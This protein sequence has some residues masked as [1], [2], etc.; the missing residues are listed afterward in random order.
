M[1]LLM[2]MMMMRGDDDVLLLLMM[3]MMMMMMMMTA[4]MMLL[5]MMMVVVVVAMVMMVITRRYLAALREKVSTGVVG[6]SDLVK[7][8][9]QLGDSPN[10]FDYCFPENGLLAFKDGQQIGK[11]SFLDHIGEERLKKLVNFIL[12][13][14]CACIR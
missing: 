6:G 4:T 10:M 8:K 2:T 11:T 3:M 5:L 13:C 9:E 14:L 7:Q 12:V 1:L